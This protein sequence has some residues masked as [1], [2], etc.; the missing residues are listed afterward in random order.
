MHAIQRSTE[1]EQS[2]DRLVHS[3]TPLSLWIYVSTSRNSFPFQKNSSSFDTVVT[4]HYFEFNPSQPSWRNFDIAS[5][6]R[7]QKRLFLKFTVNG[8]VVG[9]PSMVLIYVVILINDLTDLNLNVILV[10]I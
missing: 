8:K 7:Q 10:M 6:V 4:S 3:L 1:N 9:I 2:K 5:C